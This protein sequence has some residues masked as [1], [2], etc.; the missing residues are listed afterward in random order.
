MRKRYLSFTAAALAAVT[1]A[2]CGGAPSPA[3][4][5]GQGGYPAAGATSPAVDSPTDGAPGTSATPM[6]GMAETAA[7]S[8]S[9]AVDL[10]AAISADSRLTT[11][12]GALEASGLDLALSGVG[13]YT[14]FAPTDEAFA[15][16]PAGTFDELLADPAQ[17]G[18]LLS[19]HV[20]EG[21]VGS[22][23]VMST[24]QLTTL[25]GQTLEVMSDSSGEVVLNNQ[26][27]LVTTDIQTENGVIHVIDAVLLPPTTTG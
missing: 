23:E 16:L 8:G 15:A 9:T 4:T 17:L 14:V 1:L 3:A 7:P 19:Y 10:A 26:A 5:D 6:P 11:L 25:S 22:D 20:A 12:A 13:P 21:Q 27:R 2:A 18:A 24:A